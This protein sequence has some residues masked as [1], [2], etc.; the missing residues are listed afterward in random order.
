MISF[1]ISHVT[2]FG[3]EIKLFQ[4]PTEI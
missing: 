1:F 2:T 3:T 4:P